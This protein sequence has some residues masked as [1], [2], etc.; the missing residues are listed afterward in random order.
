M[1]NPTEIRADVNPA[2]PAAVQNLPGPAPYAGGAPGQ[3]PPWPPA[4]AYPGQPWY[5]APMVAG[6][7][8]GLPGLGQ[9][10]LGYYQEGFKNTLIAGVMIALCNLEF[11]QLGITAVQPLVVTFTI[12]FWL[13]NMIDAGR[14]AAYLNQ[15]RRG[16]AGDELSFKEQPLGNQATILGGIVLILLGGVLVAHTAFGVSLGWVRSWWPA[17]L[18]LGGAYLLGRSLYDRFGVK[19]GKSVR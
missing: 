2:A 13:Y 1:G 3:P 6:L 15:K 11:E 14:R 16:G 10:Y 12:F 9:A 7:L 18:V 5:R 19:S 17:A 8:S 4:A